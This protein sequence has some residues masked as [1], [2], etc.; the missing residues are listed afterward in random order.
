M[1]LGAIAGAGFED[2][3]VIEESEFPLDCMVNDPTGQAI[4]RSL[5]GSEEEI[6]KVEGSVC[7]LKVRAKKTKA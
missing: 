1:I 4:L 3:L 5:Q 2:V 6:R 7:S